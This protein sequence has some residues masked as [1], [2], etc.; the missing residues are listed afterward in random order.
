M[1]FYRGIEG[2]RAVAVLLVVLAHAGVP[3]LSAGFIGVDV[4]FVISGF[5]ITG[6]LTEEL[7]EKGHID[8][9]AFYARRVR[10]LLPA[11]LAMVAAVTVI[12]FLFAPQ[13]S[14]RLQLV[15][16]FW[17][18]LWNANHYFAFAGFDYFGWGAGESLFLHTWSLGVEE[19]FY[20][21][22]PVLLA[23]LWRGR[24]R[25]TVPLGLLA[26]ASFA[27][28]LLLL[29]RD[30]NLA[31]Y[32]MPTRLWQ[33]AAG[34]LVYRL[35][36][37]GVPA[38]LS[39]D[40]AGLA[41]VLLLCAALLLVDV[42]EPYPGFTALLPTA[43]AGLLIVAAASRRGWIHRGLASAALQLPGRISYGWYLW[44]WPLLMLPAALGYA[45]PGLLA[46]LGLAGAAFVV[47]WVSHAWLEQPIRRRPGPPRR[48]VAWGFGAS[49]L[50][51]ALVAPAAWQS[52]Q[53]A[54]AP[55]PDIESLVMSRIYVHAIQDEPA[56]DRWYYSA[57]LTPCALPARPDAE[58]TLLVIGD[59]VGLQWLPAVEKLAAA[60][61][62]NIVVLT[63]SAC[64]IVDEPYYYERIRSR[65]TLC[66]QWRAAAVAYARQLDPS[67]VVMGSSQYDFSEEQ[68][69]EGT[70][71]M[72]AALGA[73][74]RKI[75]VIAPTPVLEFHNP[76][77]IISRGRIEDGEL[78]APACRQPLAGIKPVDVI[79]PLREAVKRTPGTTLVELSD[80][81]CPD[82]QC[83]G[84]RDG[85]ITYRDETHLNA[86]FVASLADGFVQ[87]VQSALNDGSSGPIMAP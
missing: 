21:V 35:A 80:L 40:R 9:W 30:A 50:A 70:R 62:L 27:A 20:L 61:R 51:A 77:C 46:G 7:A 4:F 5:L 68:W 72:L 11:M 43:A 1:R 83:G 38:G 53:T 64:P 56:C 85:M 36:A 75:V 79:A 59:S 34:G 29:T 55:G 76:L 73:P 47:A 57:E 31:Y 69:R 66:E 26:A 3:G 52:R 19:Q 71:R 45:R 8:Y 58:G 25:R 18:V 17:A 86:D 6:L 82:G 15:S 48:A 44:H 42:D 87:R 14:R 84:V 41:G 10:R 39:G 2:L 16:A 60:R 67:L 65:F 81:V 33:L 28:C 49:L 24:A 78:R 23:A 13:V 54:G 32:L 22:W 12:V 74:A 37:G 63:K